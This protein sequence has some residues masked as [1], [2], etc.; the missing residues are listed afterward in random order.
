MKNILIL[1]V[2]LLTVTGCNEKKNNDLD[3]QLDG[4]QTTTETFFN[5][6]DFVPTTLET[7]T[8][9]STKAIEELTT[10]NS[11][12]KVT[13]S[14][15]ATTKKKTTT[16]KK[17]STSG[18]TTT[19][20]SASAECNTWHFSKEHP[21]AVL[22]YD[23]GDD[24]ISTMD[25]DFMNKFS[26]AN[27]VMTNIAYDVLK[28]FPYDQVNSEGVANVAWCDNGYL[29]RGI[30]IPIWIHLNPQKDIG[31]GYIQSNG[32]IKW[33]YKSPSSKPADCTIYIDENGYAKCK[34]DD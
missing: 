11:T 34:E 16:S 24:G 10:K 33:L 30:Y 20:A 7:L 3:N 9:T 15:K 27:R 13:S 14:S 19:K 31:Q 23:F 8:T 17:T 1:L 18:K 25:G 12:T 4:K 22:W 6:E 28:E 26:E 21:N 29:A 32:K 2:I 5:Q